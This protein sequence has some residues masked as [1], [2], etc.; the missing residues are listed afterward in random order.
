M[1][2]VLWL[3]SW[4]PNKNDPYAGDFIERHALA[5]SSECS[6]NILYV[7]RDS[8]RMRQGNKMIENR[9]YKDGCDATIIYYYSPNYWIKWIEK[10]HSNLLFLI[11]HNN[12]LKAYIRKNGKP[13]GINVH[14]GM[15]AGIAALIFKLRYKIPYVISEH[16]TVFCLEASPNFDEKSVFFRWLC[17]LVFG[18]A[19]GYS[20]VSKHLASALQTRFSIGEVKLIPNVVNSKIFFNSNKITERIYFIHISSLIFQKNAEQILKAVS[21]LEKKLPE[22]TMRIFGNPG[23]SLLDLTEKLDIKHLV[24]FKGMHPQDVLRQYIQ[25]STALILYSRFETF[26]CVVIE[27]N[28]CGKPVIVS[29]IPVFHENVKEGVTGL[30]VPLENPELLAVKMYELAIG[31]YSFDSDIIEKWA[32]DHYSPE[33]IGRLFSNFYAEYFP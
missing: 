21:I 31:K 7:V 27:A 13:K 3:A 1:M 15:K 9:H 28:A 16:W 24:E 12:F 2:K 14:V 10:I 5:A 19:V 29:D 22:F 4:Y 30:F 8:E 11:H 23:R 26:G 33:I 20:A 25:E 18:N 17:K 32:N 6:I